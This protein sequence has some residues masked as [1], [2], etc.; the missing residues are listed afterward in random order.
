[1][2]NLKNIWEKIDNG[3]TGKAVDTD[4]NVKSCL[5]LNQNGQKCAVGLFIPDGH[6]SQTDSA[7]DTENAKGLLFHYPDLL[8]H[9]PVEDVRLLNAWQTFHDCELST[10]TMTVGEQKVSLFNEFKR[11]CERLN[12]DTID[13]SC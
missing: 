9:M 8:D 1:M 5:Y 12:V 6:A 11:L 2:V 7:M 4:S 3:F 10:T 13:Y